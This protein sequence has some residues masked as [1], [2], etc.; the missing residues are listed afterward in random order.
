MYTLRGMV[1]S[2]TPITLAEVIEI[3]PEASEIGDLRS[4]IRH[5]RGALPCKLPPLRSPICSGRA[6]I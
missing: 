6:V 4:E 2:P 1:L 3:R 5:R